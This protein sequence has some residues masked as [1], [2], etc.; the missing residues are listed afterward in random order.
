MAFL[1][2]FELYLVANHA[3]GF[4]LFL[5]GVKNTDFKEINH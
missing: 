5:W 2:V 3:N 4:Q 1:V